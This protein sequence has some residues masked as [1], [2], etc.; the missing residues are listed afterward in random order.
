MNNYPYATVNK[1]WFS[2]E[3][4]NENKNKNKNKEKYFVSYAVRG[5]MAPVSTGIEPELK[6]NPPVY[7]P[8]NKPFNKC[9]CNK[10]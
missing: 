2:C 6:S 4:E 10:I 8:I 3:N 9:L 5:S 1:Y 7:I